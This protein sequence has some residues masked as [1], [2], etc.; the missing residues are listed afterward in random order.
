MDAES[1]ALL[2]TLSRVVRTAH[3][4]LLVNYRPEYGHGWSGKPYYRQLRV[5]PL[6]P[7]NAEGLL[8][9]SSAPTQPRPAQGACSSSGPK[10]N[11]FFLEESVR[12]WSRQASLRRRARRL[13]T[14]QARRTSC[15]SPPASRPF[16]PLASIG[17]PRGQAGTPDR[18]GH[19]QRRTVAAA[20]RRSPTF[21]MAC[22]VQDWP[23]LQ[24]AEFLLEARLF[25]DLEYTFKHALTHDVAYG[26]LLHDRRRALHA[27]VV[28]AVERL[29]R[30]HRRACRAL[31]LPRPSGRGVGQGCRRISVRQAPRPSHDQPT[32][33]QP[34]PR[35]RARSVRS[36]PRDAR[37]VGAR[38]RSA[39]RPPDRASDLGELSDP[40]SSCDARKR[41][42][43]A[44]GISAAWAAHCILC[45]DHARGQLPGAAPNGPTGS[46]HG[47]STRRVRLH[48][49]AAAI[50]AS[51]NI[52]SGASARRSI[53]RGVDLAVPLERGRDG[54]VAS[55]PGP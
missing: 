44:S 8:D 21:R 25:P 54:S 45:N 20:A 5:D 27:A 50:S 11:P 53:L 51:T 43:S 52:I 49:G 46:C 17:S 47:R 29:R 37:D 16:S 24:A 18:G 35:A 34:N 42:P 2:D 38:H 48:A 9:A 12:T 3:V 4:L 23:D 10:G 32:G 22:F 36:P 41:L 33:R 30:P 26:S 40:R 13:P 1:Q 39:L 15:R 7:E 28:T 19:R 14:R 6:P 31:G 55:F